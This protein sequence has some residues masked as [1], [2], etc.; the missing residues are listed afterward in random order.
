MTGFQSSPNIVA[1]EGKDIN[2]SQLQKALKSFESHLDVN[3]VDLA[4]SKDAQKIAREKLDE[5]TMR[6][7]KKYNK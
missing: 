7:R 3:Y 2:Q 4:T 1:A 6:L 5:E